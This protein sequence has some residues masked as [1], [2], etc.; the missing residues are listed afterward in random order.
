M[1]SWWFEMRCTAGWLV[2]W[3]VGW[4][5]VGAGPAAPPAAV[6]ATCSY[7]GGHDAMQ[8]SIVGCWFLL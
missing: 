3:L 4:L 6:C 2:G 8:L 7:V 5:L 1:W